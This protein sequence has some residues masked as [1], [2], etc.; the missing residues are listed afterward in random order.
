FKGNAFDVN[1]VRTTLATNF[2][3]TL[4]VFNALYPLIRP[5]GRII[6]VSSKAGK[7][8]VVSSA[9]KQEFLKEDLD[10]EGLIKLMKRFE[11]AVEAGTHEQ[12]GWPSQ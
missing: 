4:N 7:L 5:N 11:N 3:G 10:V 1:V 2:Y 8:S 9:L 12:D 6:N